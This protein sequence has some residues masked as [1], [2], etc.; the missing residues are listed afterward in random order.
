MRDRT[1]LCLVEKESSASRHK[2]AQ[3]EGVCGAGVEVYV[4]CGRYSRRGAGCIAYVNDTSFPFWKM[5]S[6]F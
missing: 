4:V 1:Y 3:H 6:N 5:M 2:G